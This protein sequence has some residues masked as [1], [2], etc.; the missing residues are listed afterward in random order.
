MMG[1]ELHRIEVLRRMTD[2]ATPGPLPDGINLVELGV[3]D[4]PRILADTCAHGE[5]RSRERLA[6]RFDHGL[7]HFVLEHDGRSVA[8]SWLA[9]GVPRYIDELCWQVPMSDAQAWVRDIFVVPSRRGRRLFGA[10]LGA[11]TRRLGRP[12]EYFSDVDRANRASLRAHAAAGFVP[13]ASVVA[14]QAA[15][16]RLRPRPPAALPGIHAVRPSRRVLW[17]RPEER[18]WHDRHIA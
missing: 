12:I 11:A 14:C 9:A 4:I 6:A 5:P 3:G 18:R 15:A 8:W 13:C 7:R 16:L 17:L 10:L 2:Q 1:I